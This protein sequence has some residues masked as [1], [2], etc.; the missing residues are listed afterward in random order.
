[1]GRSLDLFADLDLVNLW[2]GIST[3]MDRA[4]LFVPFSLGKVEFSR[5]LSTCGI[6]SQSPGAEGTP[7]VASATG[8]LDSSAD[9]GVNEKRFLYRALQ[10]EN[11]QAESHLRAFLTGIARR[12]ET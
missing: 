5:H 8:Q 6:F 10:V 2:P 11:E 9:F 1:L 4:H 3:N 12:M 7:L